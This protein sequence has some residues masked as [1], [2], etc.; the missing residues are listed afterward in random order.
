M[1]VVLI[2]LFHVVSEP[3]LMI[4]DEIHIVLVLISS[5]EIHINP[6]GKINFNPKSTST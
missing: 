5:T 2:D 1:L 3:T 6:N 4:S